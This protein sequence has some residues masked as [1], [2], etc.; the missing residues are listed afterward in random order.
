MELDSTSPR[1]NLHTC[2]S[3]SHG[4][5]IFAEMHILPYT[6]TRRKIVSMQRSDRNPNPSRVVMRVP[7]S[8]YRPSFIEIGVRHLDMLPRQSTQFGRELHVASNADRHG[9]FNTIEANPL[10]NLLRCTQ[11]NQHP[12]ERHRYEQFV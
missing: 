8:I 5:T 9:N 10:L 3:H 12:I 11:S 7:W 4:R 6:R 1:A 2:T